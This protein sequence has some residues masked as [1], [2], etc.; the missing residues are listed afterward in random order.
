MFPMVYYIV[1]RLNPEAREGREFL[2]HIND[3]GD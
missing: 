3:N 2:I 1:N